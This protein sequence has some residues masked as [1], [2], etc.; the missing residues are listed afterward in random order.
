MLLSSLHI[1]SKN[2]DIHLTQL[3][4][5]L[6]VGG[7]SYKYEITQINPNKGFLKALRKYSDKYSDK[8]AMSK[9]DDHIRLTNKLNR[10]S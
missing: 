4:H 1:L 5:W 2:M 6:N 3:F 7:L 10:R 8:R 9:E